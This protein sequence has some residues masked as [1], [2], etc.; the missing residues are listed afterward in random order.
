MTLSKDKIEELELE[1]EIEMR[2]EKKRE[3][4]QESEDGERDA[5][6]IQE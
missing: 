3:L 5:N 1:Y 6:E 4:A 2:D